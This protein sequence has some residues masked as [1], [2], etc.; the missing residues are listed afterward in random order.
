[1]IR[2]ELEALREGWDFEAKLAAGRDGQGAVP[3]SLWETYSAMANTEGGV[4]VLGARERDDQSLELVGIYNVDK[5]EMDFWNTLQNPSKVSA[6]V[7]RREDVERVNIDG[8]YVLVI[9][10]PKAGR[11]HRPVHLNGSPETKTFLRVHQGDRAAS[12]EVVRRMMA[13]AQPERD[14]VVLDGYGE[15]DLDPNSVRQY[16]NIFGSR[17]PDH[18]FLREDDAG[19]LRQLGVLKRDRLRS[20]EGLTLGGLL[21]L[22]REDAIRDRYPHWHLSYRE[23]AAH[24]ED[25]VR[26]K[27]RLVPDGT[28]NANVFEFYGRVILRLHEGLKVPFAL[29]GAQFRRDDTAAHAAIREAL[30][31]TLVHADYDGGGGIRVL[32]DPVGFELINPGL[33][34]ISAEQVWRGG[35]SEPRNPVLQ[36]LFSLLQLGEREGS[37]GPAIRHAWAQ[38][39]WQT[40]SLHEDTENSETH[41]LLSQVSL[42]PP[43]AVDEL[44]ETLGSTFD[45]LDEVGRIAL[46]TAY[47][48][49]G[50]THARLCELTGAH[51]RDVTLK[52]Q[53]LGRKKLLNSTGGLRTKT[54]S[55]AFEAKRGVSGELYLRPSGSEEF[56]A[57][58]EE[59]YASSE[60]SPM[61]SEESP[62]GSEGTPAA[63]RRGY[64]PLQ[65]QLED[66]LTFCTGEW[67]TLTEIAKTLGRTENTVRT[68]YLPP[69]LARGLIERRHPESPRHPHQAY[70]RSETAA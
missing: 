25:R 40:P 57:G 28:W 56:S 2:D 64:A 50:V 9:R 23:R 60:E 67:R 70:R 47:A 12:R 59:T 49:N 31:N 62:V 15:T 41:L 18:P 48:E 21:M 7:V 69:L 8:R 32:R 35:V 36:R 38:Q 20:V 10:V 24:P 34:L 43:E 27:D 66:V 39:H 30:V 45:T 3:A 51:S 5:V 46:I 19:F 29:D 4:I 16:R 17:R 63:Q 37:G 65:Q 54:Y 1:M 11:A 61:G 52:L 13:D 53:E 58:F 22:G 14:A 44:R 68:T 33:L 26:W 6:N 55:L 42:F